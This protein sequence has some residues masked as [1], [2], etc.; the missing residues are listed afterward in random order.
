MKESRSECKGDDADLAYMRSLSAAV[1]QRSPRYL[2]MILIIMALTLVS[3]IIWMSHAEIDIVVRGSGKV[4]PSSQLQVIQSLEGGVVSE[5]LVRE[6]DIVK[7]NQPLVKISDIAFASSYEENQLHF[8]ELRAK[9]ARL[10]A[11]ANDTPFQED[12]EVAKQAP[13]LMKSEKSLYETNKQQLEETLQILGEQLRQNENELLEAKGK[14]KHLRRTLNLI[15]EEIKLKKPLLKKK[16]VS[17]IEFLQLQQREVETEGELEAIDL[18]APRIKSTIEEARRKKEQG[19]LDFRNKAKRELNEAVGEA[20]RIAET[21]A[22][23]KDKVRRTMLRSPVKGTVTRLHVN[24]IGGVIPAGNPILEIVP[25]EDSLLVEVEI[26]PA[27]IADLIV[28]QLTRLKFSAYDF[29]IHGSLEGEVHF[30]SADTITN[31]EGESF[32]VVRIKPVR[33]YF[34]SEQNP[35]PIGVGMTVEADILTDKRTILQYIFKPIRRG[36]QRALSEG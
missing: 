21:Q 7:N 19:R 3:A 30:I 6:G 31:E 11:E 1:V 17:E 2:I 5:I 34:G 24:T 18:A 22:A 15:R 10:T 14:R 13:S 36:L 33:S 35:L 12:P 26:K 4:I 32:F 9:I 20:S 29:A 23:L 25:F 16:L 27:D 28:G 8:L